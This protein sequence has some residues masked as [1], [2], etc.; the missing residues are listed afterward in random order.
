MKNIFLLCCIALIS[1]EVS[2]NKQNN[3]TDIETAKE[4]SNNFYKLIKE[5][6]FKD[7]SKYFGSTVGYE[8]GL[9]ILENVN[10]HIGDLDTAIYL[11]G[12]SNTTLSSKQNRAEY[13]FNFKA[14][15]SKMSATEEMVIELINDS[16]KITGYHPRVTVPPSN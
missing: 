9:K 15:Y 12:N 13:V 1:C 5:K 2:V 3:A 14:I 4:M 10:N 8:D 16:L 11:S 7:A 6:K